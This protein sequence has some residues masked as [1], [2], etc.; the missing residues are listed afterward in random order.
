MELSINPRIQEL[1]I[2]PGLKFGN[3]FWTFLKCPFSE[4][5]IGLCQKPW[6]KALVTEMLSFSK[7]HEKCCHA[8]F[9]IYFKTI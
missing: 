3:R 6:K 1:R 2:F 4:K 7:I 9:F 8:N 5:A